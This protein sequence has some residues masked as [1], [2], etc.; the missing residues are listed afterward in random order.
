MM[1]ISESV[2]K[3]LWKPW[4]SALFL[5]NMGRS[6]TLKFMQA[7]LTQ[8][9]PLVGQWQLT[10]MEDGFFVARFQLK[11][12]LDMV[13]T[14]GPWV[15]NNQY[16]VVQRWR[17]NF[18][19]GEERTKHM[20]IWLRISR[21]PMEWLNTDLLWR[22]GNILGAT[23]KVDPITET[24][25]RGRFARICVEIDI[26]Q[27]LLGS[28]R[29][30][31]RTIKVEYENLELICFNCG[32]YGHS[33]ELCRD[34]IEEPANMMVNEK[35]VGESN[36]KEN[37]YGPWLFVSY[38]R[39]GDRDGRR[40]SGG[41]G[42]LNTRHGNYGDM[43]NTK[44]SRGNSNRWEGN[45]NAFQV[46]SGRIPAK[47]TGN[48]QKE[49]LADKIVDSN[50][51]KAGQ[52]KKVAVQASGK[53][54]GSRFMVLADDTDANEAVIEH[55]G[56]KTTQN[57]L[58]KNKEVLTEISNTLNKN[59]MNDN[60]GKKASISLTRVKANKKVV[61]IKVG[62]SKER[63]L[64]VNKTRTGRDKVKKSTK[65]TQNGVEEINASEEELMDDSAVLQHLHQNMVA[66]MAQKSQD[67]QIIYPKDRAEQQ[68]S[69]SSNDE[70]TTAINTT[71][72]IDIAGPVKF[73]EV[74]SMLTE[75][76]E[77][78]LN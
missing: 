78:V 10:D 31:K 58:G 52:P 65:N 14:G 66:S 53:S 75:A 36:R 62:N 20:A 74:A 48:I 61:V 47:N 71:L 45:N 72:C 67:N 68:P 9:W 77:V 5:K 69:S 42:N 2:E 28:L 6:H 21:L 41:A 12:D 64:D 60:Q 40:N 13:L 56:T 73:D 37:P 1:K 44:P 34:G 11:T 49:I 54:K 17:P 3:Q 57:N 19:P 23:C 59:L 63:N 32:R 35:V 25:A 38:K 33:K 29:V 30:Q 22:I 26:S 27:P 18:V 15:I 24:Q 39:N 46:N 16:L 55:V 4:E 50:S 8:K 51:S 7:K 70:P 76:M 43:Q